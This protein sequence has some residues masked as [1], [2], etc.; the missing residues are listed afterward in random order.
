MFF[1]FFRQIVLFSGIHF[2][3]ALL[4]SRIGTRIRVNRVEAGS[5]VNERP[6][7]RRDRGRA[8]PVASA[9]AGMK[10]E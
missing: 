7:N 6:M 1:I 10:V 8:E 4:T 5:E 3:S 2:R 9:E